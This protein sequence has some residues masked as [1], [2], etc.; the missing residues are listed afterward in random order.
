MSGR[1]GKIGKG[2]KEVYTI[3]YKISYKDIMYSKGN[4]ANIL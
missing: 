3:M 2:E 4:I 1:R